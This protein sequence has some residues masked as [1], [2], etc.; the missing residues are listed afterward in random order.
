ML[1]IKHPQE[2]E[3]IRTKTYRETLEYVAQNVPNVIVY[4]YAD[5]RALLNFIMK[6]D[7]STVISTNEISHKTSVIL[8]GLDLIQI[9]V[10]KSDDLTD[11]SDII[12]DP[13]LPKSSQYLVGTR[14]LLPS[15]LDKYN[16]EVIADTLR[17][18]RETLIKEVSHNQAGIDLLEV[19]NL[20]KKLEWDSDFFGVNIGFVSC[21][22][23]TPN[24]ERR[25]KDFIIKEKIDMLEYLCNCHDKKSVAT[26][27]R[28]GYSFVDIRLTFEQLLQDKHPLEKLEGYSIRKAEARDIVILKELAKDVYKLSRYY[29]DTNF[30]RAKVSAFYLGWIEKAVLGTFD[31][32][33]YILCRED[34]PIGFCTIKEQKPSAARI[35]LFGMSAAYQ[36]KGLA[37]YLLGATLQELK[38]LGIDY[39]EVV[40][41]G[42]NYGAQRLY[43]K[44]G[45]ITKSTE[46]WYH[47]WFH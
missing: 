10:G 27:E 16:V 2:T 39:V 40:T 37:H 9:I 35:G 30:D 6:H 18:G 43:Q 19:V 21:L 1:V 13:M 12:I 38:N 20:Y 46:L 24:I 23:L 41:Q 5:D 36:G 8:K 32:Y 47:K 29:Y 44:C 33:A 28:N 34:E 45:F 31:D 11:V 15:I 14:Y 42:R 25:V 4:D 22:R 17:M 7:F 26:A 3:D